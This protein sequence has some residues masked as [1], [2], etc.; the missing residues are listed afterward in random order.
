M[1]NQLLLT[2]SVIIIY[3]FFKFI[4]F[5]DIIKLN[6]KIYTKIFKLFYLKKF[7]DSGKEKL[8]F[9]Y[10]KSL[11]LVSLK[12]I[13]ILIC[14]V[15]FMMIINF[16]SNSFLKLALSIPGILEITIILLIYNVLRK[17]INAKL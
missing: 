1:I 7:S 11:F 6:F 4:K 8:I 17:K 3:E 9:D 15:F 10:S 13:F 12:I 5:T 2:C 14:V 16:F